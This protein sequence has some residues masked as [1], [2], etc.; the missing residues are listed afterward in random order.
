MSFHGL[1]A[2]FSLNSCVSLHGFNSWPIYSGVREHLDCF[3]LD[4]CGQSW[5]ISMCLFM[6]LHMYVCIYPSHT[7]A[8]MHT[9]PLTS[10]PLVNAGLKLNHVNT[11]WNA[12]CSCDKT[13]FGGRP[14]NSSK[15]DFLVLASQQR[16]IL[17]L[18]IIE[19]CQFLILQPF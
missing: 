14:P 2:Y 13:T 16:E 5:Y 11:Q 7:Y 10:E 4:G 18:S 19:H 9:H 3:Q 12:C 15:D 8:H 17:L 1:E 6:E